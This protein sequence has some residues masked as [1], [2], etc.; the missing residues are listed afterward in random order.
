MGRS[1]A[2]KDSTGQKQAVAALYI[3]VST[4]AQYEEGYSVEAQQERLTAYAKAVGIQRYEYYIDGGFTG[5]NLNRPEIKRLIE[6]AKESRITHVIVYKLDRISRSQR[7]TLYLIEDV[8]LTHNVAFI[9]IN[10]SFDTSTPFGRA[11]IG[12]LSVFAQLERENIFERTRMGMQKR[13]ESGLWMG[14]GRVPYGYDY[15]SQKGILIPNKDAENVKRIY[16]LYLQ[17]YSLQKISDILGLKYE[18]LAQQI[19]TRKSNAGYVVYNGIEYKGRHEPVISEETY[20]K[21]MIMMSER[22]AKRF[23]STTNHLLT[24]LVYCGKCGAKMRYQKWGKSGYKFVCYSQ[25]KSKEYLIRDPNCNNERIWCD[26]VEEAVIGAIFDL[27]AQIENGDEI[28]KPVNALE[29]LQQQYDTVASKIK[30]LYNLYA[31]SND[32]ILLETIEEN[33]TELEKVSEKIRLEDEKAIYSKSIKMARDSIQNI[34]DL[35]RYMSISE[36]QN[37]VRAVIEKVTITNDNI[38]IKF[39]F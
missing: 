27:S 32:D 14:G 33:K 2:K 37:T 26:E 35:W 7:D 9:S 31:E 15:D 22:S 24:G 4:D 1:M 3:R 39:N 17:G 36:R 20:D 28:S 13:V 21:A 19:L 25:Q 23:I 16:D 29:M 18:R 38:D 11:V 10:E 6:D 34:A 5:S 12:I 8:F 30:R